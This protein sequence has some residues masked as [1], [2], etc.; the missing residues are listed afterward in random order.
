M[1]WVPGGREEGRERGSGVGSGRPGI[2]LRRLPRRAAGLQ[3]CLQTRHWTP[4]PEDS[5]G[6][7][8]R[9]RPVSAPDFTTCPSLRKRRLCASEMVHCVGRLTDGLR[10]LS[11]CL[12]SFIFNI[13][14]LTSPVCLLGFR[15][16]PPI[17][18]LSL[19]PELRNPF[20]ICEGSEGNFWKSIAF[21]KTPISDTSVIDK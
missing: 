4:Y 6:G 16:L 15:L 17:F 2:V 12:S 9:V 3:T 14:S 1:R 21:L 20:E 10:L 11:V 19:V 7:M 5:V 13:S 8:A 18:S